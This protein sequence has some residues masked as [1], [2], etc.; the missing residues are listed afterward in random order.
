MFAL[1][2]L[3]ATA[4]TE[5]LAQEVN[6]SGLISALVKVQFFISSFSRH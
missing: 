3:V 4:A 2:A 6:L 1:I 5:A